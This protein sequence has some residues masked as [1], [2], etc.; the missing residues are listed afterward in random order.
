M[1]AALDYHAVEDALRDDLF[2]GHD[3]SAACAALGLH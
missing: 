2:T 1:C 3:A